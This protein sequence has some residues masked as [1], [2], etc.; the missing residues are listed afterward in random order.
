[1]TTSD[2]R[3]PVDWVRLAPTGA[4]PCG[5]AVTVDIDGEQVAV[6]HTEDGYRA[7]AGLC[8]HMAGPLSEGEVVDGTV[9]CPLHAWRYDLATG[10]RTDR[11]GQTVA[12]YPIQDRDGWLFLGLPRQELDQ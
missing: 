10:A 9:I 4:L 7:V 1:M 2:D 12:T 11:P 5:K 3:R 8:L 6:F